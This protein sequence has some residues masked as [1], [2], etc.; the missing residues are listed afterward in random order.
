MNVFLEIVGFI[1]VYFDGVD[2]LWNFGFCCIELREVDDEKFVCVIVDELK[3]EGC[4]DDKCVYVMGFFNGGGMFYYL[5]CDVV[6]VFVVV[7]FVV[8][9]LVEECQCNLLC[10][11]FV[12]LICG[13]FDFIVFYCGGVFNFFIFYD[14][15][16]IYFFGVEGIFVEWG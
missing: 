14:L 2:D 15:D 9:D 12:F 10:L 3:D 8:F 11:I 16:M 6:D 5:V 4:I 13:C 7:V 1:V